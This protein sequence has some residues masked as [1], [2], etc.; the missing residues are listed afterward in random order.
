MQTN[1]QS[2]LGAIVPDYHFYQNKLKNKE[3]G[4]DLIDNENQDQDDCLVGKNKGILQ[5]K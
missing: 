1:E 5:A 3:G 2:S 4:R